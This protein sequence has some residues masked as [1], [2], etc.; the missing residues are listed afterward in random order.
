VSAAPPRLTIT[1]LTCDE[2][3]NLPRCLDSLAPLRDGREELLIV[4]S[5]SRDGTVEI[6]RAAGA[7]VVE[8]PFS[9]HV[10][11]A[12]FALERA[13]GDW[14][15]A[16]DADEWL[17]DPLAAAIA[18]ALARDDAAVAGYEVERRAFV[19][20]AWIEGGGWREWKLRLARRR[21]ARWEGDDPHNVLRVEGAVARLKGSLAHYPQ[22]SL[23]HRLEKLDRYSDPPARRAAGS[24]RRPSFAGL[25]LEPPAVFVQRLFL[26]GGIRDGVRGV[27]L[28]GLAAFDFFVRHAKRW[29]ISW[30]APAP[31]ATDS[32]DRASAERRSR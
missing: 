8:R 5:G 17:T 10:D 9:G 6:A 16:I 23:S 22:R 15:L 13:S 32:P 29:E 24:G 31:G 7:T 14:L 11:Q 26:Q 19:L 18:A 20:G 3:A 25:L 30:R 21:L 27:V 28:A 2:A 4:D 12:R 1:I